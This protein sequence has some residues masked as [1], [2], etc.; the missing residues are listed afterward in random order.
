MKISLVFGLYCYLLFARLLNA[1]N[2]I[3]KPIPVCIVCRGG[4]R[5]GGFGVGVELGITES[6]C[7]ARLQQRLADT[8]GSQLTRVFADQATLIHTRTFSTY[9][10][11]SPLSIDWR[12]GF[13]VQSFVHITT[14]PDPPRSH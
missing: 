5:G 4:G 10:L 13:V 9:S 14:R 12:L 11:D 2:I 7:S 8:S 3:T 1:H 6:K